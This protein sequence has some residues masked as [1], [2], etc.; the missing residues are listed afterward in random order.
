MFR[1]WSAP[2]RPWTLSSGFS[3]DGDFWNNR[4]ILGNYRLTRIEPMSSIR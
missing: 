3:T 2:T 1:I 4:Q